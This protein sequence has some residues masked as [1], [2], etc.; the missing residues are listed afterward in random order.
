MVIKEDYPCD[1]CGYKS[2]V[3]IVRDV[4]ICGRCLADAMIGL[5]RS[6]RATNILGD[7]RDTIS[8]NER[9]L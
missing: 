7:S 3:V 2:K 5:S 9:T 4:G 6:F 8:E 1:N